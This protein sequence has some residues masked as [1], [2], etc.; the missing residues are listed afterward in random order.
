MN[1]CSEVGMWGLAGDV[2][3]QGDEVEELNSWI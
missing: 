2:L 3:K 1:E